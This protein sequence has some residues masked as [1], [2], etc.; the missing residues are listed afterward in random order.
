MASV[1]C[2]TCPS[3]T[4][5]PIGNLGLLPVE[6]AYMVLDECLMGS[7]RLTHKGIC[8]LRS[9][10]LTCKSAKILVDTYFQRKVTST[11]LRDSLNIGWWPYASAVVPLTIQ[12]I[13]EI[14]PI[15]GLP[16]IG[17]DLIS[18]TVVDDCPECW[19]WLCKKIP[20]LDAS[21]CNYDGWSFVAIACYSGSVKMLKHFFDVDNPLKAPIGLLAQ[22]ANHN[23]LRP[24]ALGLMAQKNDLHLFERFLDVVEPHLH[25]LR[26]RSVIRGTLTEEEKLAI[27]RYA[28]PELAERLEG[29][30]IQ[31]FD[32]SCPSNSSWHAG[33]LNG[34]A[35]LDYLNRRSRSIPKNGPMW[36]EHT[37]LYTA[38]QA[39]RLDSAR[40]LKKH[41]ANPKLTYT[42]DSRQ[43]PIHLAALQDS[44]TSIDILE[45]LLPLPGRGAMISSLESGK[46]LFSLVGG[47]NQSAYLHAVRSDL[48]DD[49]YGKIRDFYEDRAIRKC[50]LIL[51]VS[52][53]DHL[54]SIDKTA[55]PM[56]PQ[57]FE[58]GRHLAIRQHEKAR[59]LACLSGFE[60]LLHTMEHTA[61]YVRSPFASSVVLRF[62]DFSFPRAQYKPRMVFRF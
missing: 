61:V 16:G 43:N 27:C 52:A 3:S 5:K 15:E 6:L 53:G 55:R 56:R 13:S 40:W 18:E 49:A 51:R 7:S 25:F 46:L 8:A 9:F 32:I 23:I 35:F 10:A 50:R 14:A 4:S 20:K 31:L 36:V 33:A 12:E 41:G 37:P 39:N 28:T 17:P 59:K 44:E 11:Y 22:G 42:G 47:L 48:D 38:V 21:A 19:D 34:P 45:E 54:P 58:S 26:I 30:G 1:D 57:L 62:A 60:R 2:D 24:T 29:I